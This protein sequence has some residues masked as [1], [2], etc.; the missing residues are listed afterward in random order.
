MRLSMLLRAALSV[1]LTCVSIGCGGDD[2]PPVSGTD[3]G[4]PDASVG[5][6]AP[7]AR[8]DAGADAG[9]ACVA[10]A[11]HQVSDAAGASL[12]RGVAW[13]GSEYLVVWADDREPAS[14]ELYVTRLDP[15]GAKIGAD[16]RITNGGG[17]ASLP[18]IVW[19][20]REYGLTWV[21]NRDSVGSVP[22]PSIYFARLDAMGAKIGDDVRVAPGGGITSLVT[23]PAMGYAIAFFDMNATTAGFDVL[24]AALDASARI[25]TGPMGMPGAVRVTTDPG[26]SFLPS[27]AALDS[28]YGVAW[29]D[30]RGDGAFHVWFARLDAMGATVAPEV[31]VTPE[32]GGAVS[33]AWNGEGYGVAHAAAGAT[34]QLAR[35]DASGAVL[36][37]TD[38]PSA[39]ELVWTGSGYAIGWKSDDAVH[40]TRVDAAGT[41]IAPDERIEATP[42]DNGPDLI[43]TGAALALA[44]VDA[45]S[46]TQETYFAA[47]CPAP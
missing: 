11:A 34:P 36:G 42:S 24:F 35:L 3:A 29:H 9:L 13:S 46:G 15:T 17:G 7:P 37:T 45:R 41:V 23:N 33:L 16:T 6:D 30:N 8:D 4:R 38:V 18:S 40:V 47:L 19:S 14:A 31:Q 1:V 39:G 32:P 5:T 21:D 22:T 12:W 43:W 26:N 44:W 25:V 20:G 2:A 27:L 10:S 28:G